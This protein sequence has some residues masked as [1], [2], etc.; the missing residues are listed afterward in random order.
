MHINEAIQK[1]KDDLIQKANA[2]ADN[3]MSKRKGRRSGTN[4]DWSD[5]TVRVRAEGEGLTIEWQWRDWY[6]K[7]NG[8]SGYNSK[9]L[10]SRQL[11]RYAK[12]W[13]RDEVEQ[14]REQMEELK[15][16]HKML[17]QVERRLI[18]KGLAGDIDDALIGFVP[19]PLDLPK[20]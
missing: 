13:E 20:R 18:K 15:L 1:G 4:Q 11:V 10:S 17:R 14:V 2:I 8:K 12:E 7:T 9:Y 16:A 3:F 19:R 6:K 5:L